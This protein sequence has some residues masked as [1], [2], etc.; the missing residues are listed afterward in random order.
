MKRYFKFFLVLIVNS[1]LLISCTS[2]KQNEN[3]GAKPTAQSTVP[4]NGGNPVEKQESNAVKTDVKGSE[5]YDT[6]KYEDKLTVTFFGL[7]KV[8]NRMGDSMLIRTPDGV[9]MLIDSGERSRGAIVVDYLRKMGI[10]K[11]DYAVGTHFHTDHVNGYNTILNSI[12]VGKII[13]PHFINYN[14]SVYTELFETIKKNNIDVDY[15]KMGNSFNLGKEIVMEV[16]SPEDNMEVPEGVDLST[17]DAFVNNRSIVLK[18]TYKQQK[19][20]FAGDIYKDREI[21]LVRM[22][23]EELDADFL[24]VPHHGLRSSSTFDFIDAITPKYAVMTSGIPDKEVYDR[25][26]RLGSE[27]YLTG[28][29]GTILVVSDGNKINIICEK[30]R[31]LKNYYN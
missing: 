2:I 11:L 3:R 26:R 23:K 5:V 31:E 15:A 4:L 13:L 25:Y 24:K 1:F 12:S 7:D 10:T 27:V 21:E 9:T 20:I 29:D 28:A 30:E 8:G 22:A 19:F 16:I 17:N 6:K 14:S 18:M